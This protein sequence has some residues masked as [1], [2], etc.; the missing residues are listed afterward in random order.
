[1]QHFST[2]SSPGVKIPFQVPGK[3]P[4]SAPMAVLCDSTGSGVCP[5]P[6]TLSWRTGHVY[7]AP[8]SSGEAAPVSPHLPLC[9]RLVKWGG[10]SSAVRMPL[11]SRVVPSQWLHMK[12]ASQGNN[13][14]HVVPPSSELRRVKRKVFAFSFFSC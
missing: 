6:Q 11:T 13:P 8:Q 5:H 10:T 7:P 2:I 1:M 12:I 14:S 9:W 3:L 4:F